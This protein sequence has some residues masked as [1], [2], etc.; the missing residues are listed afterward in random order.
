MIFETKKNHIMRMEFEENI[1]LSLGFSISYLGKENSYTIPTKEKGTFF[2]FQKDGS[3][4]VQDEYDTIKLKKIK[5]IE[6]LE[7]IVKLFC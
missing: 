4:F 3:L 6:E 5:D 7:N 1:I 2:L